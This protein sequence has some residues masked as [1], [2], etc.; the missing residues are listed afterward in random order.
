M[1]S[2]DDFI[3]LATSQIG[4]YGDYNKYNA[5]YWEPIYGYDPGWAWCAVFQSWCADQLGLGFKPNSASAYF[6]QQFPRVDEPQRGDF[7]LFNWDGRSDQGWT[8]HIGVVE[9]ANSQSSYFGTI[10]GN[11]NDG[12]VAR[13]TRSQNAGYY[14]A[15]YRPTY[16][17]DDMATPAEVWEYNWNNTAPMGNMYNCVIAQYKAISDLLNKVN[18]LTTKVNTLAAKVDKIQVGTTSLTQAD[19]NAIKKA[20]NDDAAARMRA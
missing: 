3:A 5:W 6:A 4:H 13:C 17:D 15:F 18:A 11:T 14:V 19:I 12:D 9:W 7:V 16:G 10:E 8:D 20:V 2:A 1:A